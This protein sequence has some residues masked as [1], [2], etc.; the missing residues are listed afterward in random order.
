VLGS[1]EK[2]DNDYRFRRD[3]CIV[4]LDR[5]LLSGRPFQ[6]EGSFVPPVLFFLSHRSCS[7][8]R[9]FLKFPKVFEFSEAAEDFRSCRSF[10]IAELPE[11]SKFFGFAELPKF[12]EVV[13]VFRSRQSFFSRFA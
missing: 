9:S 8:Y 2:F 4:I 3:H 1:A 11:F 6:A 13:E 5:R 7:S 10:R 12:F